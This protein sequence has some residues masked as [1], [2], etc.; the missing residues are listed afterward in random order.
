MATVTATKATSAQAISRI[1]G[2]TGIRK[3]VTGTTRIRGYHTQS[4][5]FMV[6]STEKSIFIAYV[7]GDWNRNNV[8]FSALKAVRIEQIAAILTSKGYVVEIASG[9]ERDLR[10]AKVGA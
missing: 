2:A 8:D 7:A 9:F 5:G 10:I 6:T 4:E 3:S 1:I